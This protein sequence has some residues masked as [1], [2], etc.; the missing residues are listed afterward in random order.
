[1]LPGAKPAEP[2]YFTQQARI[3]EVAPICRLSV[4]RNGKLSQTQPLDCTRA[5]M[6]LSDPQFDGYELK[7]THR[8]T[9][10]YYAM[11]GVNVHTGT[12][13]LDRRRNIGD[14]IDIR[15][16]RLDPRKSTPI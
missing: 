3:S 5:R 9:Y 16:D 6:A 12:I 15:V 7:K 13:V 4:Q 8:A 2:A 14:V 1:M 11:D 10:I